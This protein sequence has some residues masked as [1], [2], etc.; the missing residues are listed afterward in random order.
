VN[1]RDKLISALNKNGV[2]PGVHYR[3]NTTYSM[4]RY[5]RGTCPHAHEISERLL[6]LPL[7]LRMTKDDVD[8]VAE[9]V[10]K[11]TRK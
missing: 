11:H 10:I 7:H 8:K 3:D 6:S 1:D 4:Y 5:A 2:Y 9:L